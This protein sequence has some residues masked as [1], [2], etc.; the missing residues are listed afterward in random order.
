MSGRQ[1]QQQQRTTQTT[2]TSE[3]CDVMKRDM[4]IH[5]RWPIEHI[6]NKNGFRNVLRPFRTQNGFQTKCSNV[7]VR[8]RKCVLIEMVRNSFE[9]HRKKWSAKNVFEKWFVATSENHTL[10][11]TSSSFTLLYQR[12]K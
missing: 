6:S 1:Q 9:T 2:K 5:Q 11:N 10:I 3:I 4:G 7:R 8:S 12:N